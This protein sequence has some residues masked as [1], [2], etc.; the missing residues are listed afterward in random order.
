MTGEKEIDQNPYGYYS[1]GFTPHY[2]TVDIHKA[3]ENNSVF[4]FSKSSYYKAKWDLRNPN[5][6][7]IRNELFKVFGLDPN[8]S[9][10]DNCKLTKTI[11]TTELIKQL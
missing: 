4:D 5:N 9:Y 10:L 11:L 6:I 2:D 1:I 7:N 3:T 8:K